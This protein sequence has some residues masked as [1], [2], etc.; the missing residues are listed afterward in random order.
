MRRRTLLM[1]AAAAAVGAPA[2]ARAQAY[3]SQTI[4]LMHGYDA[5]SNPDTIARPLSVPLTEILGQQIVIEP[6][7]GAAER[8]AASQIAR[9]KPD[10]YTLYLMT[11]GQA[12]VS[13]TDK[14]LSYD[15]LKDFDFISIVTRFPFVLCVAPDS[16]F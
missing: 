2:I 15:L 13:A 5:G 11:G 14:T 7:P 12:V 9:M 1:S 16:R 4:R 3:P 10:G 8:L 6:R